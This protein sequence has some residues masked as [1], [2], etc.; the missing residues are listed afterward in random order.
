MALMKDV[1]NKGHYK[2]VGGDGVY[3]NF[4]YSVQFFCKSKTAPR[5]VY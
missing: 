2:G 1:N 5:I 3:G 4:L